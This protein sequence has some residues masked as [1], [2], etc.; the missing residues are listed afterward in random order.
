[1]ACSST[2]NTVRTQATI[3]LIC[4]QNARNVGTVDSHLSVPLGQI[5]VCDFSSGVKDQHTHVRPE[6]VRWMQLIE[7]FL[8]RCVPNVYPR[9][10][11]KS[12]DEQVLSVAVEVLPIDRECM[13][14]HRPLLAIEI[15]MRLESTSHRAGIG[16]RSY[17][18]RLK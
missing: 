5:L 9:L 6:V 18:Q 3:D 1:M 10:E 12:A 17:K 14:R 11:A 15:V 2:T 16:R 7:S 13:C 4:D 8:A